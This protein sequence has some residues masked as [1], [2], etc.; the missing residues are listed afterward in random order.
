MEIV[1]NK[2]KENKRPTKEDFESI[3]RSILVSNSLPMDVKLTNLDEKAN[4]EEN[5]RIKL[6]NEKIKSFEEGYQFLTEDI[7]RTAVVG[8]YSNDPDIQPLPIENFQIAQNKRESINNIMSS[9]SLS[10]RSIHELC[11]F[12]T[13]VQLLFYE[14]A[15][16]FY[17]QANYEKSI[18][19]FI[20]L[21]IVN[22]D[23][24]AFWVGLALSYEKNVNY[25]KAIECFKSAIKVSAPD[26]L[27]PYY[28]F[29]RCS[30]AI[31]DFKEIE[32]LLDAIESEGNK[33]KIQEA[34]EYIKIKK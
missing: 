8:F 6:I 26:D 11:N 1:M 3:K 5:R 12:S 9:E 17:E 20:F 4:F 27:S 22:P 23:V 15:I 31:N 13:D 25:Y 34:L 33:E 28:G 30:E 16:S 7:G 32:D 21:T 10:G 14:I 18:D 2:S 29:I 24:Q 19:A